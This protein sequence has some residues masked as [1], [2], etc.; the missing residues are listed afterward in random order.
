MSVVLSVYLILLGG[1]NDDS[2]S[3]VCEFLGQSVWVPLLCSL[4]MSYPHL[5][6]NL[7]KSNPWGKIYPL[8]AG[9]L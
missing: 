8:R 2:Q 7:F 1:D 9:Q 3:R 4:K 6:Q 5:S